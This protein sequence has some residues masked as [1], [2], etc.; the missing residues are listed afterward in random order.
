MTL[1]LMLHSDTPASALSSTEL[2]V[3]NLGITLL[4]SQSSSLNNGGSSGGG[5]TPVEPPISCFTYLISNNIVVIKG[6][7]SINCPQS[8]IIPSEI[9][10]YPVTTLG[11]GDY[12]SSSGRLTSVVILNTVIEIGDGAFNNKLPD[13]QAF[14]YAGTDS[15]YDGVAEKRQYNYS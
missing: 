11:K 8:I 9:E 4:Y 3:S 2:S 7:D 14:I 15:N 6:Y 1:K 5:S 12:S 13:N 10:G